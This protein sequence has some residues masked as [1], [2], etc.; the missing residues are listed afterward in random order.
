MKVEIIGERG[1][2]VEEDRS[3]KRTGVGAEG[4]KRGLR[5]MERREA[6]GFLLHVGALR[7]VLYEIL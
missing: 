6:V 1:R 3:R 2:A 5:K 4:V 7:A